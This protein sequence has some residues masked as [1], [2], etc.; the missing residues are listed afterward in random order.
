[1]NHSDYVEKYNSKK[2]VVNV[3]KINAGLMYKQPGM[4]PQQ[5]HIKRAS[6]RVFAVC[7]FLIGFD[8]FFLTSWWIASVVLLIA[9]YIFIQSHKQ[10]IEGVLQASLLYP[11]IYRFAVK[12]KILVIRESA[13]RPTKNHS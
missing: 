5:F 4:M 6:I 12:K 7:G 8:L 1:M 2:I 10:A 11:Y 13:V 3:N 9:L